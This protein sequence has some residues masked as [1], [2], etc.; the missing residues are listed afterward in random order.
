MAGDNNSAY[1]WEHDSQVSMV[2]FLLGTFFRPASGDPESASSFST[3]IGG[4]D[5]RVLHWNERTFI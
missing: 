3:I 2:L 1:G 5:N 4:R